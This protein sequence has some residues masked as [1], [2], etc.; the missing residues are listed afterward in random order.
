MSKKMMKRSLALGALMAFVMTGS[1]WAAGEKFFP[2]TESL[3]LYEVSFDNA[4]YDEISIT[5]EGSFGVSMAGQHT[6]KANQ[7]I[8]ISSYSSGILA[9]NSDQ[10]EN[11]TLV[12]SAPT[13][14]SVS[15][16]LSNIGSLLS[17]LS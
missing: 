7:R 3:K 12:V 13:I 4:T 10:P 9:E 15:A 2:R 8:V 5:S 16:V 1:A 6:L 14:T 11:S 17:F